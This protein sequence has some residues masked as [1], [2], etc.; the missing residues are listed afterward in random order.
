MKTF[1]VFYDVI[2]APGVLEERCLTVDNCRTKSDAISAYVKNVP[3][4]AIFRCVKA[5]L[6]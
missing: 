1:N 2:I 6:F 3:K 4:N 5:P